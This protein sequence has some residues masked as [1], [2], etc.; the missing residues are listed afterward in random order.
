MIRGFIKTKHILT[1]PLMLMQTFGFVG[2]LRLLVKCVDSSKHCFMDF[3][4]R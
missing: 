2:Y 4:L 1:H 3:I